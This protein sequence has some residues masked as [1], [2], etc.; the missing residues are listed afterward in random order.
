MTFLA[1]Q[2]ALRASARA[3]LE[4]DGPLA[5]DLL[6]RHV[7]AFARIEASLADRLLGALLGPDPAFERRELC[8]RLAPPTQAGA[9]RRLEDI[10]FVVVDVE[11]TGGRP[12]AD[13]IV[14]IAAVRIRGGRL[15]GEWSTLVNPGCPIPWFVE[16]LTGIDDAL[17]TRAPA[18][19]SVAGP[20]LEFLGG[21]PFVAHS[22]HF[23]WQFVNA[24]LI[25]ASGGTLTNARVCTVRLARRLLPHVRRRNLDALANLFGIAIE[26]RHRAL[27]DARATARLLAHLLDLAGEQGVTTEEDLAGLCGATGTLYP[28]SLY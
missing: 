9:P 16:R 12:P 23:D 5:P 17:V 18:F 27:P 25:H 24:E 1:R 15:D 22:A 6:A 3:R 19:G 20:F 13:R 7:F 26:G 14:E 21:A 8:W 11:T 10:P 28:S 4:A 2:G